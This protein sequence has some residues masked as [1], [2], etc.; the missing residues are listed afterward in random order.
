LYGKSGENIQLEAAE[1]L[2]LMAVG[3]GT[4]KPSNQKTADGVQ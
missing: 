2:V 1:W 4:A 3:A